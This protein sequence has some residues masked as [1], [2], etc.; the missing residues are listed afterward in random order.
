VGI[1]QQ[2]EAMT[3]TASSIAALAAALVLGGCGTAAPADEPAASAPTPAATS[4]APAPKATTKPKPA[5]PKLTVAQQNAKESA[6]SYLKLSGFSQKG[7]TEQLKFEGFSAKD[8]AAAMATMK[9]NWNKEA[10]QSAKAYLDTGSFSR[11]SLIEQL[12]FEGY[13]TKQA[14][15]GADSVGL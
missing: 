13:T 14:E 11:K 7:L 5:A 6:E 4:K 3:R 1:E 9:V 8:I 12:K 2:G 15:H 10:E